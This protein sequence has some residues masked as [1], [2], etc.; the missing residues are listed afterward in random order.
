MRNIKR[1][2]ALTLSTLLLLAFTACTRSGDAEPVIDEP[3]VEEPP[4][5]V[6]PD[7]PGNEMT[8][9]MVGY[10]IGTLKGDE[11]GT[12]YCLVLKEN[13]YGTL[14]G[15]DDD[16]EIIWNN[17]FLLGTVSGLTY[18]YSFD[19]TE[20]ELSHA[21]GVYVLS[22]S[23]DDAYSTWYYMNSERYFPTVDL[24]DAAAEYLL[25]ALRWGNV[26]WED[27]DGELIGHEDAP[28]M[29]YVYFSFYRGYDGEILADYYVADGEG[30]IVEAIDGIEL[31]VDE[32]VDSVKGWGATCT[33]VMPVYDEETDELLFEVEY[34]IYMYV[35]FDDHLVITINSRE[36]GSDEW[37]TVRYYF[38]AE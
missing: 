19:G 15:V 36:V 30:I 24:Q 31:F 9:N 8:Y 21:G 13:G 26:Q 32:D 34:S 37:D 38:A 7:E 6:E 35:D 3:I 33:P 17:T 27:E 1:I 10:Y 20:M 23:D 5:V 22:L 16:E 14:F 28:G 12:K 11:D 29:P 4:V 25:G 18:E 2:F